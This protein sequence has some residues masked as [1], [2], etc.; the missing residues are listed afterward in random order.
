MRRIKE[1]LRHWYDCQLSQTAIS[2]I[3]QI[4][5]STVQDYQRRFERSGL[6][7]PL[8]DGVDDS[9]LERALFASETKRREPKDA[10]NYD[11]LLLELKRPNVTKEVLWHEYQESHPD[12][13]QYSQFCRLIREHQCLLQP[14]M[15]Q[16]HKGGEKGFLDFGEGLKLVD[17]FTGEL[18]STELYVFV[19][20]AS[21]YT[22][23]QAVLSQDL[24]TWIDVNTK[25][26][27]FFGCCP[28][29]EVPDNLKA[30]VTKACR[31]EPDINPTYA[32]FASHYGMA[33]I[34]ARPYRPKDKAKVETGVKLAKRW[35]LA[36]LRNEIFTNLSD[37]NESIAKWLEAFN[38]KPLRK[39]K[40]SRQELFELIDKPYA[41]ALPETRYEFAEWKRAKVNVNYHLAFDRHEYSVPYTLIGQTVEIRATR[42]V[43]EIF[44]N[45]QR[46]YAHPRSTKAYGYTTVAEHMPT[47]HQKYLDWTPQRIM[48]WAEKYGL[49]VRQLLEQIMAQRAHPEQAFK[50]CLGIIRLEKSFTA[51]RLNAACQRALDYRA[52]SYQAVYNILSKN[53][54]QQGATE[55]TGTKVIQHENIRGSDYY[56]EE[57]NLFANP[58]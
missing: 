6:S 5:R 20:G 46:I 13:Y 2:K 24:P 58:N 33:V 1:V 8:P 12:G 52:Y 4:S 17:T 36:R 49:S 34:P 45:G 30:A 22:W 7:W 55:P 47:A 16:D 23:A 28:K 41:L 57:L 32:D 38:A 50:S 21:N 15:R 40:K 11:H 35:I 39:F 53:L 37:M 18:R 26:L 10:L 42:K 48:E 29:V 31:Y 44:K 14:S 27:E 19:W 51:P 43:V 25:A 56:A 9:D 54:D 3:C